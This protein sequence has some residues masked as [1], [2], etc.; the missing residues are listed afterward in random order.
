MLCPLHK[1]CLQ[2]LPALSPADRWGLYNDAWVSCKQSV[3]P[4]A[5]GSGDGSAP[6]KVKAYVNRDALDFGGVADLA[7]TQQW[8][9]QE[10]GQASMEYPTQ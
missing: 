2:H 9:L 6:A 3:S 5:G 1:P 7:P 4:A 10:T 8:D